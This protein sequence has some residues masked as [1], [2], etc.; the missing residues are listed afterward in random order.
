MQR[1]RFET[2][3]EWDL[4]LPPIPERS[5]L[6][7]LEPVGLGTP[8]VESLTSYIARLAS[9]HAVFPGVLMNKLLEA[10]VQGRHSGILHIS[11][12]KKTNLLNA[13]GLRATLAVQ[14]LETLTMRSDLRH[15][16][17]L[18]WSEIL[19]LRGLVRLTK[20]WCPQCY[21]HWREHREIIFDPL[22]WAIQEVT[23]CAI[24]QI[25]LCQQC[26]NPDCA[27]T[28][29]ALCWRSRPGY[30]AYCQEWL[31]RPSGGTKMN[32]PALAERHRWISMNVGAL[33]ALSPQIPVSPSRKRVPEALPAIIQQVTQG[34]ISAFARI[35]NMPQDLGS[36]R[37][38]LRATGEAPVYELRSKWTHV[39]VSTEQIRHALEEIL[40]ENDDPPPTLTQV[41]QRLGQG[42]PVLYRCH[43][44]ACYA[45]S[46]RYKE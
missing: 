29:P 34:N 41:A 2:Y 33:L 31:G 36:L 24:H 40:A 23:T 19:C 37:P 39:R 4:T 25:P 1:K 28:L 6:F 43:P 10:L 18:A 20:A 15:L 45:I 12:G 5:V 30:C 8:W 38:R 44:T 27:R 3:E 46:A 9:A 35:L 11:Q 7:S 21:E 42:T 16:T 17:L 26:P 13:T 22:L 32:D 14:F